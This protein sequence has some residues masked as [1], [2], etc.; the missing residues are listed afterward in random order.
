MHPPPLPHHEERPQPHDFLP[1][2]QDVHSAAL[3]LLQADN[4]PLET[5][6]PAGL[7]SLP[8]AQAGRQQPAGW[9]SSGSSWPHPKS[10]RSW[11]Y[12]ASK[13]SLPAGLDGLDGAATADPWTDVTPATAATW[14]TKHLRSPAA[15]PGFD[16]P[17]TG[18]RATKWSTAERTRS[19]AAAA[20]A[21]ARQSAGQQH[22][23]CC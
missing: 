14:A 4:C 15:T 2:R 19:T 23:R 8:P 17:A 10:S 13:L 5:L 22:P 12:A 16:G 20:A 1:G 18:S 3:L 21:A 7:S 9:W 6:Q 11:K